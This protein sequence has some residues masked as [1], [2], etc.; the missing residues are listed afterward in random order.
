MLYK[1]LNKLL[2]KELYPDRN[3]L[4][5][6]SIHYTNKIL[7]Q[8]KFDG[9]TDSTYDIMFNTSFDENMINPLA[10]DFLLSSH[11]TQN[12]NDQY[13]DM[14]DY[15]SNYKIITKLGDSNNMKLPIICTQIAEL[16]RKVILPKKQENAS[17]TSPANGY[18]IT[19]SNKLLK[20]GVQD[21]D[22]GKLIFILQ[23]IQEMYD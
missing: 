16:Y 12:K 23:T 17:I 6:F 4:H 3:E 14:T 5:I 9:E 10:N 19:L 13:Q 20:T 7:I 15:L 11:E 18:I 22:F 1:E 2:P 21:N 8:L